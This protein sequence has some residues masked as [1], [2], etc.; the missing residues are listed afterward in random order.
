MF[1]IFCGL[2]TIFIISQVSENVSANSTITTFKTDLRQSPKI[3]ENHQQ[4]LPGAG[5]EVIEVHGRNDD[6]TDLSSLKRF[7]RL[8]SKENDI[9][10]TSPAPEQQKLIY[11]PSN[12]LKLPR[13]QR[14]I[15]PKK[16]Q[17]TNI[18]SNHR[19]S[20]RMW[21]PRPFNHLINGQNPTAFSTQKP[22]TQPLSNILDAMNQNMLS[23]DYPKK[24]NLEGN[25]V[26]LSGTYRHPKT[27]DFRKLNHH[28]QHHYEQQSQLIDT[29]VVDP[30]YNYKPS[31]PY[32]INHMIGSA[33]NIMPTL[34][35]S[36]N[37]NSMFK[38]KHRQEMNSIPNY[39]KDVSRIYSNLF[40]QSKKTLK[41]ERNNNN[42]N[43]EQSKT[44]P[45][46]LTLDVFPEDLRMGGNMPLLTLP[47]MAV[48]SRM[49]K[50]KQSQQQQQQ[51]QQQLQELYQ[52]S[53]YSNHPYPQVM[54]RYPIFYGYNQNSQRPMQSQSSNM[55]MLRMLKPNLVQPSQLVVHLNLYPK[56][57]SSNQRT[58]TE[59]EIDIRKVLPMTTTSTTTEVPYHNK[60]LE[61]NVGG[62][63]LNINFNVNTGSSGHATDNMH[64]QFSLPR[65]P[66]VVNS[67][68]LNNINNNNNP[69]IS[70]SY[71]TESTLG[72][73]Y[74][75][76]EDDDQSMAV[77]PSNMIYHNIVRDRPLHMMLRNATTSSTARTP[78]K[79]I[80]NNQ[81]LK[82][83]T[84]DRPKKKK[85]TTTRDPRSF[86]G[87]L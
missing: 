71:T 87:F 63:P 35:T 2:F 32:E 28:K 18:P 19:I 16:L 1:S 30:F 61:S 10:P 31:S 23:A 64:H 9:F 8:E 43:N 86:N 78:S 79:P 84:I 80:F 77:S 55:N 13:T 11:Y 24:N 22:F 20:S 34:T 14:K 3:I 54:P 15:R 75:D 73:Y 52:Q 26:R 33:S 67:N 50:M 37:G 53:F 42:N 38:R 49:P 17:Y 62:I 21:Q 82:Y 40:K 4:Q 59:E 25:A 29:Q 51:Q 45:F 68:Q 85:S 74:Y 58:S 27:R 5:I 83:Q 12:A 56:N 76:D 65:D 46:Q 57:K 7:K 36:Q 44:K 48:N 6:E 72:S 47:Q 70:V 81:K 41:A 69:N 39:S 66:Y 60:T